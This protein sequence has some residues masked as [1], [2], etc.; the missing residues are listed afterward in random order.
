MPFTVTTPLS[1]WNMS[2]HIP[3]TGRSGVQSY[4]WD[5]LNK[6]R[7]SG[8]N[9]IPKWA[10]YPNNIFC[11]HERSKITYCSERV[12][13]GQKCGLG[14]QHAI[15]ETQPLRACVG[16]AHM[17]RYRDVVDFQKRWHHRFSADLL[18]GG[19]KHTSS[20]LWLVIYRSR[21]ELLSV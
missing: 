5:E 20:Q 8:C 3:I 4:R 7:S 17:P 11:H 19:S 10:V 15:F 18:G 9:V 13:D 14:R 21:D 1:V 2:V 6:P 16:C 12:Y